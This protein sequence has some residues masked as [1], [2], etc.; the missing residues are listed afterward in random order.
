L[1]AVPPADVVAVEIDADAARCGEEGHI[2]VRADGPAADEDRA[3][4][5]LVEQSAVLR[6]YPCNATYRCAERPVRTAASRSHCR[7]NTAATC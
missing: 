1:F 2:A 3:S 7:R 4:G 5:R 6:F